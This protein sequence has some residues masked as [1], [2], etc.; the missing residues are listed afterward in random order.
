MNDFNIV[1]ETIQDTGM[2]LPFNKAIGMGTN[3][4]ASIGNREIEEVLVHPRWDKLC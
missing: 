3:S 1:E 2:F 4:I